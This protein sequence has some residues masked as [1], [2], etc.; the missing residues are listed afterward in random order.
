MASL[1]FYYASMNAGKSSS[2][3]QSAYNY[4]ERGMKAVIMKPSI[5]NRDSNNEVVSRIGLRAD[6]ITF[7]KD[8][9]LYHLIDSMFNFNIDAIF[10]DE[11]QFLT[12]QQVRQFADIVDLHDIP[13]LCYGLRT[14]FQGNM[15]EGSMELM[16]IAD[17]LVE[18]KGMCHCGKKATMVLRL[19]ENGN[20]IRD[21]N[22]VEIGGNDKYVSV[23]RH[24]FFQGEIK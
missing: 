17:R 6:A 20:I 7:N 1:Y 22:Q 18:L 4:T 14:D 23:C 13:V 2:L 3:L 8:I 16:A 21:G 10:V 12:K 24:H 15:F 9:E 5:D 11:A 19:D